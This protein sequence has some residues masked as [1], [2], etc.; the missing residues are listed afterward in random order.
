[1]EHGLLNSYATMQSQENFDRLMQKVQILE[2]E[3]SVLFL[4]KQHSGREIKKTDPH[5]R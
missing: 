2:H 1:L 4:A 5:L 3:L